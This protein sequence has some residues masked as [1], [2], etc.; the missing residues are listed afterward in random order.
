MGSVR[1][2]GAN[3]RL[4][5]YLFAEDWG[6]CEELCTAAGVRSAFGGRGGPTSLDAINDYYS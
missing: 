4:L 5:M 6:Q 2:V 1:S 3:R